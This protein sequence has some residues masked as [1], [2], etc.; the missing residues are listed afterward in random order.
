MII[1]LM[2][3]QEPQ[4]KTKNKQQEPMKIIVQDTTRSERL[5]DTIYLEQKK[6]MNQL[7][8]LIDKQ[9]K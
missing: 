3:G 1:S 4:K 9:K 7:D 6:L 5:A 2:V 8:S